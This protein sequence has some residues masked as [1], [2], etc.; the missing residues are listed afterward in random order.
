MHVVWYDSTA[1]KWGTD[2][3]I[4]YT[5]TRIPTIEDG[6]NGDTTNFEWFWLSII[7]LLI[8]IPILIV[9]KKFKKMK[10]KKQESS[11]IKTIL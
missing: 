5:T 3:E 6:W 2:N 4:M 9:Y 1:C 10:K 7:S 8:V 11:I